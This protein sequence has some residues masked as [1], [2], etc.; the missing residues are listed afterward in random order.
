MIRA[1]TADGSWRRLEI[2]ANN[3]LADE[4]VRAITIVAREVTT[5]THDEQARRA[6]ERRLDAAFDGAVDRDG[7][8][9]S[10]RTVPACQPGA[11]SPARL[12]R[13]R[14]DRTRRVR[15]RPSRRARPGRRRARRD[16]VGCSRDLRRRTSDASPR[17]LLRVGTHGDLARP[18][19]RGKPAVLRDAGDRPL[20]ASRGGGG[21]RA[22]R[23]SSTASSSRAPTR[24]SGS[25]TS[26]RSP[27]SSIPRSPRCSD[28]R[29]RRCWADTSSTSW[30]TIIGARRS[31]NSRDV[32]R[33]F[34]I[35]SSSACST[36]TGTTSG[37]MSTRAHSPTPTARTRVRSPSSTDVTEERHVEA[38]LRHER[39]RFRTL[40]QESADLIIVATV[41]GTI[42]YASPAV[43]AVLGYRPEELR[44]RSARRPARRSRRRVQRSGRA[45]W[46]RPPA[47]ARPYRTS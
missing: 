25:S 26:T 47:S 40:V 18:R 31:H 5:D 15:S 36:P 24:A 8:H 41:D 28:T 14:A 32:E 42:D 13:R 38:A 43:E 22:P 46:R 11:V 44:G 37:S 20:G 45:H 1:A 23:R 7:A 4:R 39:E 19:R 16:R 6:T 30:T 12:R 33:A 27:R 35:D 17:R 29:P 2:V 9:R 21:A 34:A 3:L 10:G